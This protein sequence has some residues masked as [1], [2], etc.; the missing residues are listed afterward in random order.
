MLSLWLLV[1]EELTL[2]TESDD[3][4]N[5]QMRTEGFRDVFWDSYVNDSF[6]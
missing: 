6:Q 3:S 2:R 5:E 4:Q 1:V